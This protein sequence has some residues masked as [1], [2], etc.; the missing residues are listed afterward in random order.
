MAELEKKI[1]GWI[2]H[3]LYEVL[4][5]KNHWIKLHPDKNNKSSVAVNKSFVKSFY[6]NPEDWLN[7][8]NREEVVDVFN[9]GIETWFS[10]NYPHRELSCFEET[11]RLIYSRGL[12][13][14][15]LPMF[16]RAKV[17]RA[18]VCCDGCGEDCPNR[19][20]R[21]ECN[22]DCHSA[23]CSNKESRSPFVWKDCMSL[24]FISTE[25]GSGIFATQP[26]AT[27]TYIGTVTGHA[28]PE[29]DY[30][31]RQVNNH[32]LFG[33]SCKKDDPVWAIDTNSKGNHLRFINSTCRE[34]NVGSFS[35]TFDRRTLLKMYAV[36]DI[37]A[38]RTET[39]GNFKLHINFSSN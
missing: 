16:I 21:V 33:T 2:R 22:D 29:F 31:E 6:A 4:Q 37:E 26:I 3:N 23:N 24:R 10:N 8:N 30:Y 28:I 17:P 34:P 14:S 36:E 11:D 32:Y 7:C 25:K 27:G 35:W 13:T 1:D 20:N 38:V 19:V 39:K 18:C 15:S 5:L 9:V 12:Y